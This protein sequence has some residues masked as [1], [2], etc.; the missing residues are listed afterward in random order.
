MLRIFMAALILVVAAAH[1]APA[2]VVHYY[3]GRDN[4]PTIPT[5]TYASQANPNYNRLSFLFGE[6][7]VPVSQSHFHAVGIYSLTGPAGS[8]TIQS[9]ST[10]NV[11]PETSS[12][13]PPLPLTPGS[14]LY[15]AT[16]RSSLGASK[17]SNYEFRSVDSLFTEP[18]GSVGYYMLHSGG[19]APPDRWAQSL[20]GS[21]VA[22][23][24]VGLTAGLHVGTESDQDVVTLPGD[25]VTL[26]AGAGFSF[27]P[28]FW[29]N[30]TALLGSAYSATFKLV[31]LDDQY[32]DSGTFTFNFTAVPEPTTLALAAVGATVLLPA[33]R[34][35]RR[36]PI[37]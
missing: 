36:V 9:T 31:D 26:G 13:E 22:L 14:G 17:Y 2:D 5:G 24:L 18:I 27:T 20:A 10:A 37:K 6:E 4:R 30:D 23:E 25:Q 8:P 7:H 16:L 21:T 15:A 35:R 3:V 12:G 28:V 32:L 33:L 1:S 19:T 34:R 11:V 29:V